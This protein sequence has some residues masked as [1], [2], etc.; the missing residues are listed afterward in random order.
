MAVNLNYQNACEEHLVPRSSTD[1]V[2][3]EV[4]CARGTIL[5]GELD[6]AFIEFDTTDF[7]YAPSIGIEYIRYFGDKPNAWRISCST[8]SGMDT[9]AADLFR[10]QWDKAAELLEKLEEESEMTSD[11]S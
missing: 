10:R 7:G 3:Y 9:A 5:D 8:G 4:R 6:S 11:G 2:G 1:P